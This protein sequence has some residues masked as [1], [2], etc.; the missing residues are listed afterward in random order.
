MKKDYYKILEVPRTAKAEDIKKA[1]RKLAMQCH[2][3]RNPGNEGWA[4]AKFKE[5]NEAFAVLGDPDKRKKYDRFGTAEGIDLGS[6]Y[7]N[8]FTRGTVE[9][10]MKD[11]GKAGLRF[12]FIGNLFGGGFTRNARSCGGGRRRGMGF[13]GRPG[14]W[15]DLSDMFGGRKRSQPVRYELTI[16]SEEARIGTR[17]VL[18]RRG[19]RL[20]VAV[21]PSVKSGSVVR[22]GGALQVTDG[23]PGDILITIKVEERSE[24]KA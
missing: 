12:D 13:Q 6:V 10:L 20:E 8:P 5:V 3:D 22:L 19:K 1:Y 7:S 2:P 21:P 14:E 11:F 16:S 23:C 9:D 18:S 15:H 4:N 24:A 17:K